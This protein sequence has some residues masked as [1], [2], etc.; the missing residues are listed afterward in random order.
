MLHE[1]GRIDGI[2]RVRHTRPATAATAAVV[3]SVHNRLV[4]SA[5]HGDMV[6]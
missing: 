2:L 6:R 3:R 4:E 5:P 1:P